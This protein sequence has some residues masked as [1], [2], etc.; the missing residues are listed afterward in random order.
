[1]QGAER[2]DSRQRGGVLEPWGKGAQMT[3]HKGWAGLIYVSLGGPG[4][5]RG[6]VPPLGD[7]CIVKV[8]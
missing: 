6:Q 8:H 3:E 7:S 4:L 5:E 2:Q 1:M